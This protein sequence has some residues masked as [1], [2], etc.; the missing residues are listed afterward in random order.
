VKLLILSFACV[1]LSSCAG[2]PVKSLCVIDP[3]TSMCWVDKAKGE[4]LELKAM[5]GY[6]CV[7]RND[8]E[9]IGRKLNSC[10]NQ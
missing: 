5:R 9:R 8:L 1:I 7:D 2:A 4:G 10:Q 3:D 6:F